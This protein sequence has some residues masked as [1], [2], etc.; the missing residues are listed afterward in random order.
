MCLIEKFDEII[1]IFY[2]LYQRVQIY[3]ILCLLLLFNIKPRNSHSDLYHSSFII[4]LIILNI[5][6]KIWIKYP[7]LKIYLE[8]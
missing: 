5:F 3:Y 6:S 8:I 7:P 1:V 2:F 4:K